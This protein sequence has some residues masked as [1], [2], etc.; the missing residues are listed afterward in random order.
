MNH[1]FEQV[2]SFINYLIESRTDQSKNVFLKLNETDYYKENKSG[3][4]CHFPQCKEKAIGSHTY[5]KS[6]LKKIS[7]GNEVYSTDIQHIVGNSYDK[8]VPDLVRKTNIKN[9]GV[10]PLFCYKHDTSVFKA[11]EL[12]NYTTNIETY[13]CLF[14]Y[15]SFIYDFQ[16]E[17]EVH[18]PSVNRKIYTKKD[19]SNMISK[20]DELKY[21]FNQGLAT[22]LIEQNSSFQNYV[23]LKHKFDSI[24][25]ET[26]TPN[27]TD[28]CKHFVLKYFDLGFLPEFFAS[29]S[30]FFSM[31]PQRLE[32]PLQSIYA[33]IPDKS[34]Q[35]AYFCI[36]MPN[37]SVDSM[38]VVIENLENLYNKYD[39]REFYKHIEFLLLDASQNI[40]M[41]ET[42][43]N[44]LQINGDYLMLVKAC[45][46]LVLTRLPI[47]PYPN[48][49]LK[50]YSYK[51][52][53]S[54]DLIANDNQ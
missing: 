24:F 25:S 47:C 22:K 28:F 5:P 4:L 3:T 26:D 20:K 39:K 33:I 8:G 23:V 36:L 44:T 29:G 7:K 9:S 13:L 31:D 10:Q 35:T 37:E 32:N 53:E 42:L 46:S 16:L 38:K 41:T 18:N 1:E 54:I 15:R 14:L 48:E 45:I 6:V 49:L 34:L 50:R 11:V 51:L 30:M 52:L 12:Q 19:Y 40:I 27:Y 17:S 21:L 43:Y 2:D